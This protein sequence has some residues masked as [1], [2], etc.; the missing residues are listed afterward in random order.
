MT[1]AFQ[2]AMGGEEKALKVSYEDV[3]ER[4]HGV[5]E[6]RVD[7]LEAVQ[8]CAGLMR[9]KAE[10]ATSCESVVLA[11]EIDAGVVASMMENSPHVGVDSA[12]IEGVIEE[13]VYGRR[14][15]DGV[16]VAVV[17]DIEQEECLG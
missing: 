14:G 2:I 17:G 5:K 10:D 1:G 6:E 9:R 16:V 4:E 12:E 15:G 7:V 8:R 11:M 3:V 13:F